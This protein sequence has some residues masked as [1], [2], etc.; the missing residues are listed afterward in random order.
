MRSGSGAAHH[1]ST[2]IHQIGVAVDDDGNGGTGAVR[3]GIR[4][5]RAEDDYLG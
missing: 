3:V 1:A 5:T 4:V 2:A